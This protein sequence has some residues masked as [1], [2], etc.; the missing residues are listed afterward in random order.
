[1]RPDSNNSTRHIQRAVVDRPSSSAD[2]SPHHFGEALHSPFPS[3]SAVHQASSGEVTQ[4]NDEVD[5]SSPKRSD[6]QLHACHCG[7]TFSRRS[8]FQRHQR[9]HTGERPFVCPH[10]D[11]GKTFIQ[12]SALHVHLRVHTGERPHECEYPGCDKTFGDSSSLARH[13][14]TH[15]GKRPYKCEDRH[16]DR[17]FTRRTT[18]T[19]HMR[20]HDP[21]YKPDPNV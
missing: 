11:C 12:R 17:T 4:E 9:I 6:K 8:D 3:T 10:E 14:R 2:H 5:P 18:L 13:R 7:K 21:N 16:C 19:A 1:M 15:T 20:S